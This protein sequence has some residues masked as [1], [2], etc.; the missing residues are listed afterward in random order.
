MTSLREV[1]QNQLNDVSDV[2]DDNDVKHVHDVGGDPGLDPEDPQGVDMWIMPYLRDVS[3]WPVLVVL[4]LHVVA[5]ISP[6]VLYA[7]RDRMIGP[8]VA[9]GVVVLLTLRGFRWEMQSRG[10]FGA[11]SWLFVATWTTSFVAAYFANLSGF[12]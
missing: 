10:Q 6:I 5:F 2:G 4:I 7:V 1:P 8:M 12:F 11:I 9:L 3:L